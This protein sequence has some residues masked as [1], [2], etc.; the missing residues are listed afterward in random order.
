MKRVLLGTIISICC[1][2]PA[3]AQGGATGALAGIV[4]D[5]SGAAVPGAQLGIIEQV[6]G[7]RIRTLTT[8]ERGSFN[9]QRLPVGTYSIE[10]RAS[11]FSEAKTTGI[12]LTSRPIMTPC[13][14]RY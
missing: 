2:A 12:V 4:E 11:G 6:S 3:F 5:A 10:V 7:S 13:F 14:C 8:D 1:C 9:A